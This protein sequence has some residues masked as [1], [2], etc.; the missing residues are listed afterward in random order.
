MR[1]YI[2]KNKA[3]IFSLGFAGAFMSIITAAAF[4]LSDVSP[5]AIF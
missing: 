3:T 4:F 2:A 1:N 5:A